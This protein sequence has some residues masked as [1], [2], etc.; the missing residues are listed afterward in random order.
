MPIWDGGGL[1]SHDGA[2]G[3]LGWAVPQVEL[4]R[5]FLDDPGRFLHYL[6]APDDDEL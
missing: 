1:L 5:S 6:L 2:E 3:G 4:Y